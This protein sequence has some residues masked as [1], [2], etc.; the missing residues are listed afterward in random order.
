[1]ARLVFTLEDGTEI[2]TELDAD[3]ISIGRH[4]ESTVVLPSPSVSAHHASIKRRGDSFFVQDHATTNGTRLNGVDVEEARLE[5]GDRLSFGDV[6]ALVHMGDASVKKSAISDLADKEKDEDKNIEK[7]KPGPGRTNAAPST[8]Y[9][10]QSSG[11]AGFLFLLAFLV[12][13][14]FTGICLRYAKEHGGFLPKVLFE[15]FSEQS[16]GKDASSMKEDKKDKTKSPQ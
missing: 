6:P 9:Y 10:P 2:E 5:D 16:R 8:A 3:V 4:P 7:A 13:A 15:K 14:F 1:M 11:C 12:F